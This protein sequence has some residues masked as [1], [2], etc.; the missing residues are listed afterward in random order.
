MSSLLSKENWKLFSRKTKSFWEDYR[1]NRIGLLGL[2][3]ILIYVSMALLAPWIAPYQPLRDTRL[4]QGFAMPEWVTILPQ[5]SD[6]PRT[7]KKPIYWNVSEE[8]ELVDIQ[9]GEQ[10]TVDYLGDGTRTAQV[11]ITSNFYYP[12]EVA[13][14]TVQITFTWLATTVEN[15]TYSLKLGVVRLNGTVQPLWWVDKNKDG[16]ANSFVNSEGIETLKRLNL[17]PVKTNLAQGIFTGSGEYSL[18]MCIVFMPISEDATCRIGIENGELRILGLVHGLLGTDHA[19]RDL[20]SQ[21]VVGIRISLVIGL[22]AAVISTTI[23]IVVGVVSG[24]LGGVVDEMS[25]RIVDIL[26]CLP[27]LPLLLTLMFMF[28]KSPY[29]LI[30]IIAVFWWLGLSRVIRSQALSLREMPFIECAKAA[31]AGKLYTIFR[32]VVPNVLPVAFAHM[33]LAVPGAIITEA[34]LS[35]LGFGDPSTS[36][37][38][39][40]LNQAFVQGA[41]GRLAWWWIFPPG[42]AIVCLCLAFVFVGHAVDEIANPRLRRRR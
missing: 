6:F 24:F 15:L 27:V 39:R 17:D 35:F 23:G 11:Y 30:L 20:Y 37:W 19:G 29:Y 14:K 25:M 7:M 26:L 32:H 9:W 36:T 10:V 13:P 18:L 40:M 22:L 16:G 31:G 41:F 42:L 33:V 38:G 5:Y 3:T 21:L 34:S 1:R 12:Y 8:S 2:V 4:A 28:G